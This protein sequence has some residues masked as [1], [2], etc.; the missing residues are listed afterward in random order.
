MKFGHTVKLMAPKFV[1]PYR[2]GGRKGKNDAAD[3]AAI[4]EAVA[5]PNMR[6]VPIKTEEQHGQLFIHRARQAY[7]AERVAIINRIRGL[8]SEVGVVMP[9]S[10]NTVRKQT[11]RHLEGLPLRCQRVINDLLEDTPR[12]GRCRSR[13][14]CA[15]WR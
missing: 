12:A 8:L 4:C 9:L 6:F 15:G 1:A 3:A 2:M 11:A 14:P 13:G 7:V 5:G 10:A